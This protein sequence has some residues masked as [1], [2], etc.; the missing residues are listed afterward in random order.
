[1]D[2]FLR[3]IGFGLRGLQFQPKIVPLKYPLPEGLIIILMAPMAL[4]A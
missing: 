4:L 2:R 3:G 1:M